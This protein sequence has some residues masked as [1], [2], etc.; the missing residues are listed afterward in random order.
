MIICVLLAYVYSMFLWLFLPVF[1]L[2][3]Q[4]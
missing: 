2:F 1:E 4:Y 3:S